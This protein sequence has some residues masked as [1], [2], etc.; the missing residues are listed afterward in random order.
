MFL[1]ATELQQYR[2][3]FTCPYCI[4]DMRDEDRRVQERPAERPKLEVL[5]LPEQCER[6][7]RDLEGRV[8][9]WNERK[10]CK[11]CVGEEQEKWGL[12]GGGPM[13]APYRVS[14]APET[15]RKER[16]FIESVI[17]EILHVLRIKRKPKKTEVIVY[18]KMPI[19]RA[20]PMAEEGLM[21][22]LKKQERK[23][24]SEGLMPMKKKREILA[25]TPIKVGGEKPAE[26]FF[27]SP[28][29]SGGS[30]EEGKEPGKEAKV[31]KSR[32]KARKRG[33]RKRRREA[34]VDLTEL[35][36]ERKKKQ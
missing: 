34:D 1:P 5:A 30:R 32:A 9:I 35:F 7:G 21:K 26:E 12:V 6:C 16:G 13:A 33:A 29:E 25:K 18:P 4:Q 10:L 22:G 2:G 28:A 27:E 19:Q 15:R 20:K 36:L 14:P 8:Y 3:Q 11:N 31:I 24:E 23:P 17:S